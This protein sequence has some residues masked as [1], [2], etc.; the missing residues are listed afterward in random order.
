[1]GEW[2]NSLGCGEGCICV[3]GSTI[4]SVLVLA[5]AVE[6]ENESETMRVELLLPWFVPSGGVTK[7]RGIVL[8][9]DRSRSAPW[10]QQEEVV[11]SVTVG[12]WVWS[13]GSC[14]DGSVASSAVVG[15]VFLA[16]L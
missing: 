12:S 15:V 7:L 13:D 10:T 9:S 4:L 6:E 2:Y 16:A 5:L 14:D 3:V 8:V 1:M 11:S